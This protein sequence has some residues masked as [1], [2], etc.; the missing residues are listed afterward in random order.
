MNRRAFGK[1]L[2][3]ASPAL[4]LPKLI[5]VPRWKK[6][7]NCY[8]PPPLMFDERAYYGKWVF[9]IDSRPRYD[10]RILEGGDVRAVQILSPDYMDIV[11]HRLDP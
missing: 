11:C 2:F 5:E 3:S 6:S 8:G 1:L 9:Y 7:P 4:F 10:D